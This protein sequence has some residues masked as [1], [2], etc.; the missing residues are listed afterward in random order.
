MINFI[1]SPTWITPEFSESLAS[2][3]RNTTF[4]PEEI[5]HFKEDK[6]FF[7]DYRKKV[8]NTGSSSFGTFLKLSSRQQAAFTNFS[9]MMRKR[10]N[11][12]ERL[13]S[14]LIP[15]F[16]VGCRRHVLHQAVERI[17][18]SNNAQVYPRQRVF[19]STRSRQLIRC[20]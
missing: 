13:S 5:R 20:R 18:V 4:T 16:P 8:Q 6:Q 10:L 17:A 9:G 12:D 3:G 19:R 14:L 11:N 15:H 1:R 2:D 7:L